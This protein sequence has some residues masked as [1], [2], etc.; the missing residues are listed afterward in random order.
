MTVELK[1]GGKLYGGWL[2]LQASLSIEQMANGFEL[3]ISE[4]W[5][6]QDKPWPIKPGDAC[7][8]LF[9]GEPVITGY[10]DDTE[11]NYDRQEHGMAIHGRDATGDLVDCAA[12]YKS[13]QWANKKLDAIAGDLCKPFGVG[14]KVETD[15]GAAFSSF[16]IEPGET[17]FECLDRAARLKAVLLV[18]DGLGNLVITRAGTQRGGTALV[19]GVNI[20]QASAKFSWRERFSQVAVMG[21]GKIDLDTDFSA[22]HASPVATVK[23]EAITRY[24]PHI[25][26][27]EDHGDRARFRDRAVWEKNVRAGRGARGSITVQGWKDGSGK[28]WRPNTL[29]QVTSPMLHLDDAEMLIVGCLFT[30]DEGGSRTALSIA[31]REAFDLISGIGRSKLFKKLNTKEEREKKKKADDW[32]LAPQ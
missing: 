16:K 27:A 29:V 32:G 17:A 15:V 31:R 21:H 7:E 14:V 2:R 1:T 3:G 6:G 13:G 23:D 8:L 26:I 22:E 5:T 30:L 20:L 12:I 4:L 19:E 25:V 10:V 18:S 11:I 28:I 24:R 9:D